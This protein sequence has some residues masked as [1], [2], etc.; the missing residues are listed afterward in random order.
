VVQVFK[1]QHHG[2]PLGVDLKKPSQHGPRHLLRGAEVLIDGLGQH[3][4]AEAQ[5]EK[6]A[7]KVQ[8]LVDAPVAEEVHHLRRH[9]VG[10]GV[11]VGAL[12]DAEARA[13]DARHGGLH[14]LLGTRRA[15]VHTELRV[16]HGQVGDDLPHQP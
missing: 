10:L 4:V 5:P 14:A 16:A 9:L 3:G 1:H 13:E 15:A 2:A 7:E 8:D 11:R 12:D 6:G